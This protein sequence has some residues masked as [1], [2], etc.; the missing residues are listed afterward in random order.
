MND[1]FTG[2][3]RRQANGRDRGEDLESGRAPPKKGRE[4]QMSPIA[5]KDTVNL[6]KFFVDVEGVKEELRAVEQVHRRL[7][8]LN[9]ESKKAYSAN[10]VKDLRKKMEADVTEALKRAKVIKIRL[11]ALDRA[12]AANRCLPDCGPGSSTD[13]TRTS[14]VN[15]LRKKLKDTMDDFQ[16]MRGDMSR[17]YKET[18]ERRYFTVTGHQADEEAIDRLISTGE[19]EA[20]FQ[21]AIQE[22]GRAQIMDTMSEIQERRDAVRDIEKNLLELHQVFLD[23]AVLV[24]AQGEQ[25]NDIESHV[26]RA[27]SFVRTGAD[28]LTTARVYQKSTRKW[29]CIAILLVI[30]IIL[31][32]LLPILLKKN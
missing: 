16:E 2:S 9:E 27:S 8:Q 12:N 13:R 6:D 28:H 17:E 5:G 3:F 4:V 15:G 22:Q 18:I 31:I 26:A 24:E 21:R 29:T 20:M 1:L 23:M 11:E 32:I 25:L 30:V 10:A 7:Q 19:S 14:V